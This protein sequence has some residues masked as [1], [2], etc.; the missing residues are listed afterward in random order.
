MEIRQPLSNQQAR[1]LALLGLGVFLGSWA[2]LSY[3][4]IVPNVIL[5]PTS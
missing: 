1:G 4:E 3:A 5:P 2:I